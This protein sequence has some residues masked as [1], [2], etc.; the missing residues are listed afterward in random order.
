MQ[1]MD[2]AIFS[3]NLKNMAKPNTKIYEYSKQFALKNFPKHPDKKMFFIDDQL[4]N[5]EAAA[6]CGIISTH[7]DYARQML[8]E[9]GVIASS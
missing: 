5:T 6:R 4:P 9:H 1:Y 2:A 3:G 7:P 8:T